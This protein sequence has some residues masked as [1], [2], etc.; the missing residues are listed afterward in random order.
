MQEDPSVVY[1]WYMMGCGIQLNKGTLL[2]R[3][4]HRAYEIGRSLLRHHLVSCVASDAHE[5]AMRT[6][7]LDE[8]REY[9]I[10]EYN[11]EYAYMLLEENPSRILEG[12]KLV[13]Y[14]P[15]AYK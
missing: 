1:E 11:E 4:G 8:V 3:N 10:N 15:R 5:T 13:G 12:K 9:L 2:K 7:D 14:T 6:T